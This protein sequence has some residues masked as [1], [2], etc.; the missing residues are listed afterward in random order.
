MPPFSDSQNA[1]AK[2]NSAKATR[3]HYQHHPP[4]IDWDAAIARLQEM[5][6]SLDAKRR[7]T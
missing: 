3:A 2:A 6:D 5:L 7:R 1:N 4:E